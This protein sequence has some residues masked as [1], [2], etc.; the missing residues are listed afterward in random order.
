M[1]L[2]IAARIALPYVLRDAINKRLNAIP[3]YAGSVEQIDVGLWR[4]AYTI[5]RL[6]ITKRSGEVKEPFFKADKVDFSIAW[7]ELFHGRLVSDIEAVKPML[8]FVEAVAADASQ[9]G[10]SAQ[11]WQD[12]IDD[13][14][15][16]TITYFRILDGEVRYIDQ[17]AEPKVDVRIAHLA[18][19]VTGLANRRSD[20]EG[21][22]PS[23]ITASGETIGSGKLRLT[24]QLEPLAEQ[25][26]FLLKFEVE[27]VSL[28]ALNEFLRAYAGVDVSKGTFSAYVEASARD[29]R[30][31]GYF[32]PFFAGL[33]FSEPPGATRP[34]GQKIWETVVRGLAWVFKNHPRNEVATKIPF[35]GEFKDVKIGVWQTVKN[36]VRHAFVEPLSKKLDSRAS[37]EKLPTKSEAED[38][39]QKIREKSAP[40]PEK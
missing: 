15:P 25:P 2:L 19:V 3:D 1:V 22:F 27:G 29:G 39:T 14:F 20:A 9:A 32:K 4:G 7:R 23:K 21:E 30:F 34:L 38:K 37:G 28:P 8:T 35:A 16:I 33:D 6:V 40:K 10:G 12:V 13:I 36:L 17:T 5:H 18:A 11:R 24:G 26:H 31:Q